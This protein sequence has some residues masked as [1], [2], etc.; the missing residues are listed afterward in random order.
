MRKQVRYSLVFS[1]VLSASMLSACRIVD[2]SDR[3]VFEAEPTE[4]TVQEE[5][6]FSLSPSGGEYFVG[7]TFDVDLVLAS[8]EREVDA[9]DIVLVYNPELLSV[10]DADEIKEGSQVLT[11][12]VF[13]MHPLNEVR[14]GEVR[15]GAA[16]FTNGVTGTNAL[17]TVTF[18]ARAAGPATVKYAY[19]PGSSL[20][21]DVFTIDSTDDELSAVTNAV[22][23]I[24]E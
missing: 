6:A 2:T 21:T 14:D 22:F 1:L 8:G 23:I 5:I 7:D 10:V 11:R 18:V 24:S 15:I 17:A 19:E 16:S 4:N 20:D 13:E 12:G 9:I 3:T